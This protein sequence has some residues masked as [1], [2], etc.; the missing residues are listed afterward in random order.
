MQKRDFET[1]QKRFRDFEILPKFSETHVFW[2]TIRHPSLSQASSEGQIKDLT[3]MAKG[4]GG[5]RQLAPESSFTP[6]EWVSE[7]RRVVQGHPRNPTLLD[8][9]LVFVKVDFC[10]FTNFYVCYWNRGIVWKVM[11]KRKSFM[12]GSTLRF[13]HNLSH[14]AANYPR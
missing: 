5:S 7:V 8:F 2:G 1:C 6:E 11:S 4:Q 10:C 13:T 14:S 3:L 12:R 9:P